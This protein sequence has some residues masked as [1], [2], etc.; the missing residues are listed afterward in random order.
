MEPRHEPQGALRQSDGSVLWRVWAPAAREVR[1]VTWANGQ[2]A[3]TAMEAEGFGYHVCR[4]NGIDEGLRYAYRLADNVG[5]SAAPS[6]EEREYPDPASRWQPDGV[7]K[8]SALFFPETF[9]WTDQAWRGIARRELVVYEL[10]VGT[11][12]PE[13]TLDAIVPRL[14]E[15]AELG[16]TALELMP[17]AQFPGERN[18]GYDGV[19]PNA[20]QNSYGGPRAYAAA[21]RCGPSRG[22]GSAA[23]RGLQPPWAGGKSI[24]GQFGPY[25]TD[26]YQYTSWGQAHQSR[27]P[28]QR[29]GQAVLH[30]QRWQCGF[31][32]FNIDGLRLDAIH[33]IA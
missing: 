25:F 28:G 26:H 2:R 29:S 22:L 10:H 19:H 23:R 20:V 11:F 18:W 13:G 9:A 12:T 21:C 6:D 30:R 8:P 33:A 16:V 32:I 24:S 7:H 14:A 3:E 4:R 27:R 15:L 5:P 1:L 17:L 31:A